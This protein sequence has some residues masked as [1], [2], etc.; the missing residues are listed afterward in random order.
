VV[1]SVSTSYPAVAETVPRARRALARMAASAGA[2]P[3]HID[4]VRLA[5]SEVVT[6]AVEHA[7]GEREGAVH[8][9]ARALDGQLS[10]LVADDGRGLGRASRQKAG[11][12]VG[13]AVAKHM[14]D[15]FSLLIRS[16]GGVEVRMHFALGRYPAAQHGNRAPSGRGR[17]RFAQ[18]SGNSDRR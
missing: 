13:I 16:S 14:S 7:Y 17:R 3:E 9:S 18:E 4:R 8:V 15:E 2:T 11:L 12:G 1:E 10:V 5:V 6:N